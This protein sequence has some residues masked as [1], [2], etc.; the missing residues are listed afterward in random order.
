[1][2]SQKMTGSQLVYHTGSE[3]KKINVM[4]MKQTDDHNKSE[5]QSK[6][7]KAVQG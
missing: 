3:T 2:R 5:K 6:S 7:E 4:K 1:M